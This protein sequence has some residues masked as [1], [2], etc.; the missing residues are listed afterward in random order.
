MAIIELDSDSVMIHHEMVYT[1]AALPSGM[2]VALFFAEQETHLI[3]NGALLSGVIDSGKDGDNFPRF[4]RRLG[5]G[6][7]KFNV[8][9]DGDGLAELLE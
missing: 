7:V 3:K 1:P 5:K 4:L 8:P 2:S 6:P 9:D